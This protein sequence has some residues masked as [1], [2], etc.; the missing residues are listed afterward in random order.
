MI[1][2]VARFIKNIIDKIEKDKTLSQKYKEVRLM[3]LQDRNDFR[4]TFITSMHMDP[5]RNMILSYTFTTSKF[6]KIG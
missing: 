4:Y 2:Y 6:M 3:D 1:L 5:L